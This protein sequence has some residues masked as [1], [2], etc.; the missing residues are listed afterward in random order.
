[1][2]KMATDDLAERWRVHILEGVR[3]DGRRHYY[4]ERGVGSAEVLGVFQNDA[5]R[6]AA[7]VQIRWSGT[8]FSVDAAG[9]RRRDRKSSIITTLLLVERNAGVQSEQ[10]AAVASAHCAS[11]GA[12]DAGGETD[13]CEYCG[14]VMNDGK[15]DWALV[16]IVARHTDAGRALLARMRGP[17]SRS[18]PAA[19][20]HQALPGGHGL[21]AW[22]IHTSLA[23]GQLDE[24]EEKRLLERP[25]CRSRWSPYH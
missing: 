24:R 7:V 22:M 6:D 2:R 13:A 12:P 8:W 17:L 4:G 3:P 25:G 19:Q 21:V 5:G 20:K 16:D 14:E 10:G 23:D 15:R 9:K 18:L 11:C 1:M